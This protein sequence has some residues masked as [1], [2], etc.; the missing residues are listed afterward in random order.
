MVE[1]KTKLRPVGDRVIAKRT[2]EKET[3]KGGILLPDTA[4]EKQETATVIAVA[5][6]K[7]VKV[8]DTILMDRYAGQEVTVD[9]EEFIIVKIDDIV[10]IVEE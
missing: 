7:T 10:A 3:L 8:G 9:D 6:D 2:E 4:K 1:T 5:N